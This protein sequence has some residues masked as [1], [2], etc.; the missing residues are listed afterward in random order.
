MV[1]PRTPLEV[2]VD[3]VDSGVTPYCRQNPFNVS[4]YGHAVSIGLVMGDR[5][6]CSK[7]RLENRGGEL[8]TDEPVRTAQ[9]AV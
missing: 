1:L 2:C 6:T 4:E 3:L 5:K 7:G 8:D 9:C